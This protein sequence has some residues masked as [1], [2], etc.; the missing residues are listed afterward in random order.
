MF[1]RTDRKLSPFYVE[2]GFLDNDNES[3]GQ[4]HYPLREEIERNTSNAN[5]RL[6][7]CHQINEVHV[8]AQKRKYGCF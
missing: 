8:T 6:N 7:N 2:T 4:I 5:N 1:F 3:R